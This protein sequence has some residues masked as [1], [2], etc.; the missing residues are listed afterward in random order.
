[1]NDIINNNNEFLGNIASNEPKAP[2]P[3]SVKI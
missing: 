1:M 2:P 3:A